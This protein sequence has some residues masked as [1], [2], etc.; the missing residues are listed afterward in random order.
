MRCPTDLTVILQHRPGELARGEEAS[1][2]ET[3]VVVPALVA[4]VRERRQRY[5]RQET[6]DLLASPAGPC[7][8]SGG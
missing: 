6:L 4:K 1:R 2:L 7:G 8:Q 3:D 5:G